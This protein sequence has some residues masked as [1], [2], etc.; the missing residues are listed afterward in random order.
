MLRNRRIRVASLAAT[1]TTLLLAGCENIGGDVSGGETA[2]AGAGLVNDGSAL[3]TVTSGGNRIAGNF[4]CSHSVSATEP[5]M[6]VGS[7]GLVGG[8]LTDLLGG[9]GLDVVANLLNSVQTPEAAADA[10]LD[11]AAGVTLTAGLLGSTLTSV[12]LTA[13]IRDGGTVPAGYYA[14]AGISFPG[15]VA[16]LS[17]FNAIT[18]TTS[19]FGVPRDTITLDQSAISLLGIDGSTVPTAWVGV[20]ASQPYD[21]VT[22]SAVPGVLSVNVGNAMRVHEFC[23]DGRF[24]LTSAR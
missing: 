9:L 20:R 7:N 21:A 15:G 14:V 24:V 6:I 18:V 1:A 19:L 10:D 2:V 22:V 11:T 5:A 23:Y 3:T 8:L 16:N 13:V 4:I 12:D 17:L